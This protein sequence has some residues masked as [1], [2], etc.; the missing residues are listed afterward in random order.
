[1]MC[2]C[3]KLSSFVEFVIFITCRF[4][5][6]LLGG[7]MNYLH[8]IELLNKMDGKLVQVKLSTYT[9]YYYKNRI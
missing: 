7:T 9:N 3:E 1:M 4:I 5:I 6:Y 2:F 8:V